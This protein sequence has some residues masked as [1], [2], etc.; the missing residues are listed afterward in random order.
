MVGACATFTFSGTARATTGCRP[1]CTAPAPAPP[2]LADGGH[3]VRARCTRTPAAQVPYFPPLQRPE[4][5]TP[6]ACAELMRRMAGQPNLKLEVG[7]EDVLCVV[8]VQ[9]CVEVGAGGSGVEWGSL[10]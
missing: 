4:D 3:C 2:V 10:F 9:G 8:V 5:F 7:L 6:A 1:P